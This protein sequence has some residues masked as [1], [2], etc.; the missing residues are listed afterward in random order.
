[1]PRVLSLRCAFARVVSL[2]ASLSLGRAQQETLIFTVQPGKAMAG[3]PFE[4]QPRVQ[5]LDSSGAV[6][7]VS[8]GYALVFM[9][10]SPS[11]FSELYPP[12]DQS[13]MTHPTGAATPGYAR[14]PFVEGIALISGLTIN[15]RGEGFVLR[16]ESPEHAV[17]VWSAP[18]DVALGKAFQL[19]SRANKLEI[20]STS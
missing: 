11:G 13:Y 3:E 19:Q 1:M 6:K 15:D 14:F 9:D 18:F 20:S 4:Q 12:A 7:Q 16:V 17:Q 2:M 5:L 10:Q 8:T